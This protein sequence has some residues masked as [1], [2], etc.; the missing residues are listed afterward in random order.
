[1]KIVKDM[2]TY[3]KLDIRRQTFNLVKKFVVLIHTFLT[4]Q[5]F[6]F[7]STSYCSIFEPYFLPY[8]AE[9]VVYMQAI[10]VLSEGEES[11][12]K[13]PAGCALENKKSISFGY[14][15]LNF[16][17]NLSNIK[18][19]LPKKFGNLGFLLR[20]A[21]FGETEFVSESFDI[22]KEKLYSLILNTS[23]GKEIFFPGLF[24]GFDF[25][26]G[27]VKF[28]KTIQTFGFSFGARYIFNF[29]STEL[30]FASTIGT[31]FAEDENL[32]FY[33]FG[34]KYYLPEYKSFL[35]LAYNKNVYEFLTTTFELD[36]AK[37]F[38]L[39][40]GYETSKGL[41][42]YSI[43]GKFKIKNLEFIFSTRYNTNLYFTP[44]LT[45]NYYL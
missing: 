27:N 44:S 39:I 43:G 16:K 7:F 14:T 26:F 29:V 15:Y 37:N 34:L 31:N 22:T 5:L 4:F 32:F 30:H 20:Y 6:I 11:C 40:F 33:A 8:S 35:S 19:F 42:N 36:L 28:D 12:A 21:D 18:L 3:K 2:K 13:N 17:D 23:L 45:I 10:N 24:L 9:E 25:N 1:V 38:L 41:S